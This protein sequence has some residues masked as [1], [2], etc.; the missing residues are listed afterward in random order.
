MWGNK[1]ET[2]TLHLLG[3]PWGTPFQSMAAWDG[4]EERFH[5]RLTVW[6]R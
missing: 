4:V 5:K 1:V 2:F 3:L 6:K